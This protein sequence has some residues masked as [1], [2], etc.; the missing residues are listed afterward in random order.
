MGVDVGEVVGGTI[1]SGVVLLLG[2]FSDSSGVVGDDDDGKADVSPSPSS[3]PFS[4]DEEGG[5]GRRDVG[6]CEGVGA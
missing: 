6:D 5:G 1:G 4:A 3:S 2:A